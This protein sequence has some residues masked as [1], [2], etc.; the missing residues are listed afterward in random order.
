MQKCPFCEYDAPNESDLQAH[1]AVKHLEKGYSAEAVA[2]QMSKF[3][4]RMSQASIAAQLT[5]AAV[6]HGSNQPKIQGILQPAQPVTKEI[7][8]ETYKWFRQNLEEWV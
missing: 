7:I 2:E 1:V 5:Y 6:I 4:L 3:Q 8:L